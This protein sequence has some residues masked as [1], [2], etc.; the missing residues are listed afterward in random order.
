M[1]IKRLPVASAAAVLLDL[2]WILIDV[3]MLGE[4]ARQV[5][6]SN[7]G[8]IGKARVVLVVILVRTSH[9]RNKLSACR[10]VDGHGS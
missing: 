10:L 9:C 2:S 4:E 6:V 5:L 3:A 8:T 1:G 7:S